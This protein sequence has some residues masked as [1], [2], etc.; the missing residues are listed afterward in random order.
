MLNPK[1]IVKIYLNLANKFCENS[2]F[3]CFDEYIYN[4]IMNKIVKYGE[5]CDGEYEICETK[6]NQLYIELKYQCSDGLMHK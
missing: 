5:D 3:Q 6:G 4:E 2:K 1:K